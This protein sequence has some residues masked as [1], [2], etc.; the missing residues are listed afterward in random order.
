[1]KNREGSDDIYRAQ[2][3]VPLT[4]IPCVLKRNVFLVF[5]R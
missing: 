5:L 4:T 2:F 1:M 3:L